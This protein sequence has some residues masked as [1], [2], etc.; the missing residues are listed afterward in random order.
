M[1]KIDKSLS[2]VPGIL[3]STN[4]A[5][6]G[7]LATQALTAEYDQGQRNFKFDAN[8]YGDSEVKQTLKRIQH[9]KCCFCESKISH[10]AYGDV[11]H[12][13]PKGGYQTASDKPLTQPGYYWLAY[14]FDNLLLACQICNQK[15][16]RNFFPLIDESKRVKSHHDHGNLHLEDQLIIDPGKD[17]PEDHI[18]FDQE[19]PKARS[20]K[21]ELTIHRLGLDRGELNDHRLDWLKV[22]S[23]IARH[24]AQGDSES[25]N[26]LIDSAT[27]KSPFSLMVR[28]NFPFLIDYL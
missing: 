3:D 18:Y 5:S 21:G 26:L 10:I 13:R 4:P 17:N 6:K 24:A 19:I 8:V 9:D 15:F 25:L 20:L 22:I 7:V 27:T 12:F 1:I 28:S 23:D 11:E 2:N 14:N 16:K